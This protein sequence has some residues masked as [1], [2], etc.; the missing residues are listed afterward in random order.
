[1]GDLGTTRCPTCS[2]VSRFEPGEKTDAVYHGLHEF[3]LTTGRPVRENWEPLIR[4]WR[5]RSGRPGQLLPAVPGNEMGG[6]GS[7]RMAAAH[8]LGQTDLRKL[9]IKELS[10]EKG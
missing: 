5:D 9:S 1:M 8:G 3:L 6:R 4:S 7:A 10:L 2:S